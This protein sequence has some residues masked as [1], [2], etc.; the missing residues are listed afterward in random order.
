MIVVIDLDID[1]DLLVKQKEALVSIID[2]SEEG[3]EAIVEACEGL[4]NL[5]DG[6]QDVAEEKYGP[7]VLYPGQ[8]RE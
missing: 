1:F 6:I 8:A 3:D 2:M 5:I 7:E 4:L